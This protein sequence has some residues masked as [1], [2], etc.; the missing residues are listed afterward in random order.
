MADKDVFVG[1]RDLLDYSFI[2]LGFLKTGSYSVAQSDLGLAILPT[3][4]P[5]CRVAGKGRQLE[6]LN[7]GRSQGERADGCW[8]K[9]GGG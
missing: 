4:L 2:Y 8:E 3:Q 1:L 5:E 6:A 7:T 9:E